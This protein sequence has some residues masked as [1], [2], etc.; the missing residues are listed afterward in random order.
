MI[1]LVLAVAIAGVTLIW[2]ALLVFVLNTNSDKD[3]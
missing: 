1:S 3:Q 2:V